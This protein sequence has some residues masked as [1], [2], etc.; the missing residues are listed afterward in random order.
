MDASSTQNECVSIGIVTIDSKYYIMF[1]FI[2]SFVSLITAPFTMAFE[3]FQRYSIS[4]LK[5]TNMLFDAIFVVDIFLNFRIG[6]ISAYQ[7]IILNP[8]RIRM[9]YLKTWFIIDVISSYPADYIAVIF[10]YT[11]PPDMPSE[12]IMILLQKVR[13]FRVLRLLRIA[14]LVHYID[15]LKLLTELELFINDRIIRLGSMIGFIVLVL[16][17]NACIQYAITRTHPCTESCWIYKEN[18]EDKSMVE[19]YTFSVFRAISQL[20][21]MGYGSTE[22]PREIEDLWIVMTSFICGSF[23][24][25]NILAHMSAMAANTQQAAMLYREKISTVKEYMSYRKLPKELRLRIFDY[26]ET[27][28]QGK[29]FNEQYIISQMS[30]SLKEEVMIHLC[31]RLVRKAPLFQKVDNNIL[32]DIIT[33]LQCEMFQPGDIVFLEGSFGNK[34]YFIEYGEVQV[35]TD[36]FKKKLMDGDYF[37]EISLLKRV[38]RTA[39]VRALTLCNL[40]SLNTERFEE[41]CEAYPEMK[42]TIAE[43][44]AGR[45]ETLHDSE[46]EKQTMSK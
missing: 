37:G 1:M 11:V 27:R 13:L 38:S 7:V 45:L 29:W 3:T 43:T 46:L 16:H 4:P 40:F 5:A 32:N 14:R 33:N 12:E 36:F 26:Y 41:V 21:T 22:P 20:V 30:E 8:E 34:M 23:M 9:A 6:Y 18:L 28:Y 39:T 25:Q 15:K 19:K 31:I 2:I 24:Y 10:E 17:W 42:K 35:E 44:A